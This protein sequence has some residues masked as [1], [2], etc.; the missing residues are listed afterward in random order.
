MRLLLYDG[1]RKEGRQK[2]GRESDEQNQAEKHWQ[3]MQ[4][5]Q[6]I[7]GNTMHLFMAKHLIFACL[8]MQNYG[9]YVDSKLT[10]VVDR[11]KA[12]LQG[13]LLK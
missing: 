10:I 6:Q 8:F 4:E 2:G 1:I 7:K 12:L 9:I 5:Q 11:R 13:C 3:Q